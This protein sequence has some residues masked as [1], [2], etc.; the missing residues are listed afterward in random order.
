MFDNLPIHRRGQP[1]PSMLLGFFALGAA[2]GAAVMYALDPDMG[3][4]RRALARDQVIHA[5]HELGDL[6]A[7]VR[8]RAQDMRNRAQGAAIEAGVAPAP[9]SAATR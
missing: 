9:N 7:D 4:R 3:R 5:G 8:G 6:G 2:F 1:D